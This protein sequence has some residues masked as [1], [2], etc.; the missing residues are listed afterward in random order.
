[1]FVEELQYSEFYAEHLFQNRRALQ[2]RAGSWLVMDC[3]WF[4]TE[5]VDA[6]NGFTLLR[7]PAFLADQP[8]LEADQRAT[9]ILSTLQ[10]AEEYGQTEYFLW[11]TSGGSS[12]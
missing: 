3:H 8:N 6:R 2:P 5:A 9:S 11:E 1:M 12:N 10:D 7:I 4:H